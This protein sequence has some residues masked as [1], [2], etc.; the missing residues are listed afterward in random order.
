MKLVVCLWDI[1]TRTHTDWKQYYRDRDFAYSIRI[2][3][4]LGVNQGTK[5]KRDQK[6]K[7]NKKSNNRKKYEMKEEK[8]NYTQRHSSTKTTIIY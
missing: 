2:M 3:G 8:D 4:L 6:Q 1:N 7:Q 5:L